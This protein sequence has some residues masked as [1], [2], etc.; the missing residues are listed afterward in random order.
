MSV[1]TN[2]AIPVD[3]PWH[4]LES[5]QALAALAATPQG[6]RAVE[7]SA[8]LARFGA[9][10]LPRPQAPGLARIFLLQFKSPLIYLLLA[11]AAVSVALGEARDAIF[12]AVVLL[13]NAVIGAGQEWRAA[14]GAATLDRLVRQQTVVWRDGQRA[15]LDSAALVP[16][17]VIELES[18]TRVPADLRLLAGRDLKLDE[19]LLTGESLP[20]DKRA[21]AILP[22]VTPL[23]DRANL[24][25][26]GATVLTG[27]ATGLVIRTGYATE[28]GRIARALGTIAT[29]PPLMLRLARFTRLL[30]LVTVVLI[31]LIALLELARGYALAEV[32]FVA[33]ALAVSAIPEGLPVAI[34]IA[35]A[36]AARRMAAAHVIVRALPAVEGLGAC[37]VIA[38]DKT[39]TLTLNALTVKRL[40]LPDI[41]AVEV[42]GEGYRR[43]G[44]VMHGGA[45]PSGAVA[46]AVRRLAIAGVLCNEASWHDEE[47]GTPHHLGD[48]VDVALLVLGAKLDVSAAA[49]VHEHP[50]AARIP[51]ES[52]RR[53][54]AEFTAEAEGLRAW[55]KGAAEAVLPMCGKADQEALGRTASELAAQGYRVLALAEGRVA[56]ESPTSLADLDFLGFA[57]LIDPVRPEVPGAIVRARRAGVEVKM[58]TGDHPETALAIGRQLGLAETR[59][60][61]VTGLALKELGAGSPELD[62]MVGRA[63]IF[64]RVEPS[65]K[66][67]IVQA[68]HRLGHFTAVTGDGVNDAPALRVAHIGVAM[69]LAGTDVARD[70]ADLILTDDNFAAIV[71]GI[72]LG[73]VAYD[74]VRKLILLL[75][76]TGAAEIVVFLL[77]EIADLPLPLLAVQ[78][79]WLNLVTNGIQD[80]ALAFERGEPGILDRPPRPPRQRLL[81][82]R[83]I[84]AVLLSGA[85]M[86]VAGFAFFWLCLAQGWSEEAARNGL[87]LLM[88]L[89][90]NVQVFNC[91]SE[92]RSIRR[93][94]FA[95]NPFV[96]ISVVVA[97]A[98]HIAAMHLPG[99]SGVLQIAPVSVTTWLE[100]LC[101]SLTLVVA[102]EGYKHF[103]R[104]AHG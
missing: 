27:R 1:T 43:T 48:T 30:G 23:G 56:D 60:D 97:Q 5:D 7:A 41:G 93:V 82:P 71:D 65:Q 8:R 53:Y 10:E 67:E 81:D 59:E 36:I 64:A 78:L 74:N 61:V 26:A 96:V 11:A 51:F 47:D 12:I 40:W 44:Q 42:E 6:L 70:S 92:T 29:A 75:V 62:A 58:V 63:R 57:C 84:E 46:A 90:E 99:L 72:E 4:A 25:H 34:S 100:V 39:G 49:L 14:R 79:L 13:M 32:F 101:V 68:L 52:E 21:T 91:R 76:S 89:F 31:A 85:V 33:V 104:H 50:P 9:N 66:L 24:L 95:A 86:G 17:D 28:I 88:V 37:T 3:R 38:T 69:G 16:G 55:V 54:A 83:M 35:L 22:E 19:S 98:V 18:G 103:R 15:Q 80:V 2:P 73:R 102:M 77:A 94:P 20:V 45:K 87:L